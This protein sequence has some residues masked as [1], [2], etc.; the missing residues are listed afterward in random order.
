M[1]KIRSFF[2]NASANLVLNRNS[3]NLE[4]ELGFQLLIDLSPNSDGTNQAQ[5]QRKIQPQLNVN[6]IGARHLPTLFGLKS[7]QGYVVK[8]KLFPGTTK[9]DSCIQTNSWP[10]FNENFKFSLE[11]DRK[12]SFKNSP[13][14]STS[15]SS[16][17][18]IDKFFHG[19]FVVLTVYALLELPPANFNRLNKT[20]RSL[21]ERSASIVQRIAEQNSNSSAKNP[22]TK[23]TNVKE[24]N[25]SKNKE[26]DNEKEES[27]MAKS[28]AKRNI[29]TVT[30][31]LESKIFK[32]NSRNNNQYLTDEFWYAIKD[33]TVSQIP[34]AQPKPTL[35]MNAGKGQL[36]ITIEY[37]DL[38]STEIP[39]PS[40]VENSK[41]KDKR[42][43]SELETT[44]DSTVSL[45][46]KP[47]ISDIKRKLS[48]RKSKPTIKG[49]ILKVT[50]TK[51]RCS[52]K[53]KDEFESAGQQIYIKT[54]VYDGDIPLC[55]W[56]SNHFAPSLSSRWDPKFT[57]LEVPFPN[58]SC[59]N[60]M[61]I[62]SQIATKGKVGRKI[63]LASMVYN[64]S[65]EILI[66]PNKPI[67][68]W[69]NLQ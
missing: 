3:A 32:K 41:T 64:L 56:K 46:K 59:L 53:V 55:S 2:P 19:Q 26:K 69:H 29:G 31:Y 37:C 17:N 39:P 20:Y 48:V 1:N 65:D 49:Y 62:K 67:V 52:I 30:C 22:K 38:E 11:P 10:K 16:S 21:K 33:L 40:P 45:S 57:R 60:R 15:D 4:P 54:I 24:Q 12:S 68:A 25:D 44:T 47:W 50:T 28:E 14:K 18:E 27:K 34:A 66:K 13:I 35:S 5:S 61:R 51:F 58:I 7:V 6:L 36:E 9:Y 63:I 23:E 42:N 8:V 43:S